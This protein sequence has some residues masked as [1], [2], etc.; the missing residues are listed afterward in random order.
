MMNP[1]EKTRQQKRALARAIE[2]SR[3]RCYYS[4]GE[5]IQ[6]PRDDHGVMKR[7]VR[8]SIALLRAKRFK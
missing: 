4:K 6:A 8:R 1:E 2:W 5:L 3:W 7:R